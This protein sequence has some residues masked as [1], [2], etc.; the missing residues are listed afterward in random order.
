[1]AIS[2]KATLQERPR[3]GSEGRLVLTW[4]KTGYPVVETWPFFLK[5]GCIPGMYTTTTTTTTRFICMTYKLIQYCKSYFKNQNYI[6]GQLRY[7]G[8][9]LSR[10]SILYELYHQLIDQNVYR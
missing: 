8:N 1:M 6:I 9:N 3:G 2:K 5:R 7:F 10:T 4:Q